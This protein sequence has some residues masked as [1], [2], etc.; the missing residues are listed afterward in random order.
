[1]SQCFKRGVPVV[2]FASECRGLTNGVILNVRCGKRDR[3]EYLVSTSF[4]IEW[5]YLSEDNIYSEDR[6]TTGVL[7]VDIPNP[8]SVRREDLPPEDTIEDCGSWC[9]IGQLGTDQFPLG[10]KYP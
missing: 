5:M 10:V 4:Y 9:Y 7:D 1:M 2:V 8:C 3:L 6:L